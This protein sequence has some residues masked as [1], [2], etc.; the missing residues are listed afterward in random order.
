[1]GADVLIDGEGRLERAIERRAHRVST[2]QR[3]GCPSPDG[4]TLAPR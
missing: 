3:N 1:V 2:D 4:P